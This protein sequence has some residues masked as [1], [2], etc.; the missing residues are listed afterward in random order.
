MSVPSSRFVPCET[1]VSSG[2][3][4]PRMMFLMALLLS[5]GMM[6]S[7]SAR[8]QQSGQ[9]L[10]LPFR[11]GHV[12]MV[13]GGFVT[14]IVGHPLDS[15]IRYARTDIGGTYR[16]NPKTKRWVPLMEFLNDAQFNYIGTEAIG[17]D[18]NNTQALYI[19]AGTYTESF[20]GPG[21]MLVSQDQGRHFTIVPLPIKL[22][23]NDAGRFAGERLFVDPN[24]G[25]RIYFG[26]R[27]NGL[28][29]S[30]DYGLHWA[31][32]TNFP[33]T[34]AT[35]TTAD[36][37]VGIIFG[38]FDKSSGTVGG[39]TKTAY[40]GVSDNVG[41]YVTH[42]GGASFQPVAGQ[43]TGVY[44]NSMATDPSGNLYIAYAHS[45]YGNSVG[46]YSI[47]SGSIWKY[48]PGSGSTAAVWTDITP[49]NPNHES[50]GFGSVAVDQS[51]PNVIMVGTMDRYYPPP[52]DDIFRSIDGGKTWKSLQTNSVRDI[53][54]SPWVTF[55]A[56]KAQAGNWINHV[57]INP[58][59]GNEV[60]YGNGQTIWQTLDATGADSV[61]TVAGKIVVGGTT[62]WQI[63][64]LGI[65]ETAVNALISPSAGPA[66]LLSG[67]YDLSGFTHTTLKASPPQGAAISPNVGAVNSLDYAAQ[68]PLVI[69]HVG[70]TK[71]F[72]AY[73]L[74]GGLTYKAF[75]SQPATVTSSGSGTIALTAD[76][77]TIVWAANDANAPV[78]YSADHGTTWTASVGSPVHASGASS[79]QVVADRIDPKT[80]YLYNPSGG[81][82]YTSKDMG[83]S[84][85]RG[86]T[87]PTGGQLQAGTL[88]KGD[89]W[90]SGGGTFR[91]SKDG[92]STFTTLSTVTSVHNFGFG[93]PFS[94]STTPTIYLR[95]AINHYPSDHSA[96]FMS[97]DGG[98]YWFQINDDQHQYGNAYVMTGDPRVFGRV[99]IATNGLGI[100]EGDLPF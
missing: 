21:A 8:A 4:L 80:V 39:A 26:S 34:G 9:P 24:N 65:E 70:D 63:G 16:W 71:P 88:A 68:Q 83:R 49:A 1:N 44:P 10:S 98:N 27:L 47:N 93:A 77:S 7:V 36:P 12:E 67:M 73:S 3:V 90:F 97:I 11:W 46:P 32:V 50:Y 41:L 18:P 37:G 13:G 94:S 17:L 61:P 29:A 95:G 14:G 23:S 99:Y 20:E 38:Y 85:T 48:S 40:I 81:A 22:G 28:W 87:L 62:H 91:R 72:G 66:H 55:G 58:T 92:G 30:Q 42:D 52:Q 84:F 79:I 96:F 100:V 59:N 75:A 69:V 25:A 78:Y 45:A 43:P 5:V 56:A 86:I 60:L 35:G 89:L 15:S 64:A 51:N 53:S 2:H 57:W 76:A 74:D 82:I 31:Q 19:A 33:V 54:L 6:T